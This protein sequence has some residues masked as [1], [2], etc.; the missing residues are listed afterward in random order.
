MGNLV[1]IIGGSGVHDSPGFND[2][3]WKREDTGIV[4]AKGQG[5]VHYQKRDDGVIFIPRHGKEEHKYGPS[6]TQYAA[7]L[8]AAKILGANV[9]I[10]T[11]VVSS[12]HEDIGCE[13]LVIPDGMID[14]SGRDDN[15]WGEGIITHVNP[16]PFFSDRLYQVLLSCAAEHRASF[17]QISEDSELR[18]KRYV[19]IP[20]DRS[21]SSDEGKN[22]SEYAEIVGKTGCPEA[23]M[24]LQLGLHYAIAAFVVNIDEDACHKR[25]I[26]VMEKMSVSDRVPEFLSNVIEKAKVLA[27]QVKGKPLPQLEGN[28]VNDGT[29]KIENMYLRNIADDLVRTYCK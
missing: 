2:L 28:V 4:S 15:I 6:V 27:R 13:S 5:L 1:A 23:S 14:E 12:L 8:V 16:R 9:V 22:R 18:R 3:E 29:H 25:T 26:E 19:T 17:A 7:N 10:G 24:A 21:G 20:G 11:S